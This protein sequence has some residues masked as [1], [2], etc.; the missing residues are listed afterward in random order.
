MME[1]LLLLQEVLKEM[2]DKKNSVLFTKTEC[3]ILSPDFKLPDENQVLLKVPRK[4]NMYSFDLKNVVSSMGLTCLFA[5]ATNDEYNLWHKRL[6]HIKFKTMNK[7]VKG[8]LVRGLPSKIFENDHTCVACQKEKQHKASCSKIHSDAGQEGKEKVS[9][10]EYILLPALNTSLDVP[11]SNEEVVSSPKDDAGK[12]STAEPTCVE[13]VNAAGSSFSHPAALDAFSKMPNLE[14]TRIFDDAYDDRDEGTEAD[15]NTLE[16]VIPVSPIPST[17]IHKD[18]PKEQI[19][20]EM[21]PKKV[22]QDLYDEIWVE[23]M[24]EELLQFKPLNVWTMVDLPH[25]KRAIGT[26]WVYRNKRDQRGIIVRNKPRLVAQGHREEEGIDYDDVF[27][28][29]ARIEA[30]KLFLAYASFVD[31]TM[32]QMYVKSAFLYGTIE[33]EVYVSQPP[34][35]V[36]P[37]FP[38]RVYKVEKALYGLHQAPGAWY[39][40]LSNYLLDNRF[41]RGTIDKTLFIKKIKDDILLVQVYVDDIIF[42]STK[43]SRIHCCF[44]LLWIGLS[45]ADPKPTRTEKP[46]WPDTNRTEQKDS[47][48]GVL[49]HFGLRSD[50]VVNQEEGDR[51]ERA[52][53]TDASLEAAQD[54]YNIIMTQ[55]MVMPNVDIPQGIDTG[56]SPRRQETM[57]GTS[58][59]TRSERVL[60][61]PNEPPLTEGHTSRSGEGRLEENIKLTNTAPTPH[62]SPLTGGYTPGSDGGRITLAELIETCTTLSNRVTQLNND[63]STTK[64]VYNKAFV[65]LTN[66]VKKLESQLK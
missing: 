9:D 14:D 65:T 52:I 59:Q 6:G 15:Y 48:S 21:E 4:N 25:G 5:K 34:G 13:G 33:E 47:R 16:T 3:L 38:D 55:T 10:Q 53:T 8:N 39:E 56:G 61:Q 24:Q 46:D 20:R 23:A 64:A 36:D 66:R 43:R 62:D 63:L 19:I 60:A 26:K 45:M 30:I 54:S 7:L 28:H 50:E 32:Y 49:D 11:S 35:F 37:E 58:A 41:R 57:G 44:Q 29:V 27:A 22:T 18:H 42:S 40:T 17:R 2:C 12:K 1:N 31:F 51:V